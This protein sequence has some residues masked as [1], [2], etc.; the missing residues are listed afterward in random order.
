MSKKNIVKVAG[1]VGTL[2]AGA[3]LVATAASGTGAWFTDSANGSLAASTGHLTLNTTDANLTFD[4]L[5]PGDYKTRDIAYNVDTTGPSDVWLVFD[6]TSP[7]VGQ[8]T[9]AKGGPYA[10]GGLGRYGHFEAWNNGTRLFT[11]YN[12]AHV[13]ASASGPA[14]SVDANGHGG[15]TQQAS[16]PTDTPPYCGVPYAIKIA[17][18]LTSGQGGTMHLVFGVTGK[19]TAQNAP[20][21]NVPFKV[22]A[23]QSGHRPDALNY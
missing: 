10:D 22:V 17:S 5:V 19:W 18:N 6:E 15:S 23:T 12:L 3:A 7:A 2:G 14:C 13:P 16:S 9:G 8:F 20:V 4:N 11:S 21:T 1:F